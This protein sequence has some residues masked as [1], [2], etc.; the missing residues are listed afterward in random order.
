MNKN[1]IYI[2]GIST[3][4]HDS[5]ACLLK[6]GEIIAAAQEERFTRV[7]HDRCFPSDAITFCHS[8]ILNTMINSDMFLSIRH[9]APSFTHSLF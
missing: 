7:K 4:Y 5:P 6:N 3:F 9:F 2:L 8:W 1:T